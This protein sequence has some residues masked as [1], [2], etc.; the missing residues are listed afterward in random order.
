MLDSR[1]ARLEAHALKPTYDLSFQFRP[2]WDR[3]TE[4]GFPLETFGFWRGA[5]VESQETYL[6]AQTLAQVLG[7][8]LGWDEAKQTALLTLRD[9]RRLAVTAGSPRLLLGAHEVAGNE[10]APYVSHGTEEGEEVLWVPVTRLLGERGMKITA[11]REDR[12]VKITTGGPVA[13]EAEVW[14]PERDLSKESLYLVRQNGVLEGELRALVNAI[15][16]AKLPSEN[17]HASYSG[18]QGDVRIT[19]PRRAAPPAHDL[20][21]RW[22]KTAAWLDGKLIQLP[23]APF[24]SPADTGMVPVEAVCE[25]FG[26]TSA[27][28]EEKKLLT[29]SAP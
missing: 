18:W 28:D 26:L 19:V 1:T 13:W 21:L 4:D 22:G 20:R 6:A 7:A 29:I 23:V 8:T 27:Y 12:T 25:A 5:R 17:E 10:A 9:Q 15:P 2:V 24:I 3:V 14:G 16:G 11:S